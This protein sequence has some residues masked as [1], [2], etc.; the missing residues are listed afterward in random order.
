MQQPTT[1]HGLTRFFHHIIA[2]GILFIML[3]VILRVGFEDSAL[4]Q[5]I[6]PWHRPVGFLT[7][8][9]ILFRWVWLIISNHMRPA[10]INRLS[11]L[12]HFAMYILMAAVPAIGLMR[13][14]ASGREFT[15]FGIPLMAA[16]EKG[17]QWMVELGNAV[18][19]L[20]GWTLLALVVG[21]IIMSVTHATRGNSNV[22]SR[23]FG[24]NKA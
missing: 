9:F 19:G 18:H 6:W 7:G 1:Y 11:Q 22:M 17:P 14:Y 15:P 12:G 23:M 8:I 4:E 2:L 21:H 10:P 5:A 3:S 20:L 16:S 13:Q 24:R